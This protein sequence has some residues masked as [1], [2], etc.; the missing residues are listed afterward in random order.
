M[1]PSAPPESHPGCPGP[2]GGIV[3][4]S[5]VSLAGRGC[6][7]LGASGAGKSMLALDL[8]GLGASLVGDDRIGLRPVD[9]GPLM[10]E[11][12]GRLRGLIEVR[13]VGLLRA[14]VAGAA[15]LTLA[16]D[17]SQMEPDRLP[18]WRFVL[19]CGRPVPLIRGAKHPNLAG[20][21]RL[22][23]THGRAC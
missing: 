3:H 9:D 23:L 11:P 4:A 13:G 18:P 20:A 22:W 2:S 10:M 17:L 1:I 8:L 5:A 19:F 14:P 16:V 12:V 15:P 6:L 21:I 7:V